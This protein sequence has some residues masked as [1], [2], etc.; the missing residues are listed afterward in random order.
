MLL[1]KNT[2]GEKLHRVIDK[3]FKF[4]KGESDKLENNPKLTIGDVT[5]VNLTMISGGTQ[6]K[7]RLC[8]LSVMDSCE[9]FVFTGNVVP[10]EMSAVIDC[11]IA[12]DVDFDAFERMVNYKI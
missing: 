3:F 12:N 5:T 2:A 8:F 1:L 6:G 7:Q 4:R 11:R 9:S 10:P